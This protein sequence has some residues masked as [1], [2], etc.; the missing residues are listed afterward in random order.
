MNNLCLLT[1]L[2]SS[3]V[4]AWS[5]AIVSSLAIA[6]GAYVVRWQVR[7]QRRDL[8]TAE[9]QR[10]QGL[11][12]LLCHL[13]DAAQDARQEKRKL[14]RFPPGHPAEPFSRYAEVARAVVGFSLEN[15]NG[16]A[17]FEALL[18]ARR[19]AREIEPLVNVDP[20]LD[21]DPNFQ[22]TFESYI[23]ILDE[24]IGLLRTEAVGLVRSV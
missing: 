15:C 3:D 12:R 11:A 13:R 7:R 2:S 4:A 8:L 22:N 24:Q 1:D 23:K 14:E 10:M 16:E 6:V 21:L 5:Q 19:I 9:A 18:N 20:E 17:A